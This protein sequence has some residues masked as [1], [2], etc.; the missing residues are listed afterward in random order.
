M[1]VRAFGD[2]TRLIGNE[3]TVDLR[4]N[5]TFEDL[6]SELAKRTRT[7][8]KGFI[9]SYELTGPDLVVLIN[10]CNM[11]TLKGRVSLNNGDVVALLPPFV[12]G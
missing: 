1:K 12:G 11:D 8:K 10:G 4:D 9:G 7:T 2:L 6:I 5:A 3:I